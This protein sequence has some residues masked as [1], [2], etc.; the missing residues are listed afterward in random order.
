[1]S[2]T[3]LEPGFQVTVQDLGRIGGLCLGIPT[4]GPMDRESFLLANRLV[5]N[6]DNAAGLECALLGPKLECR[7]DSLVAVTG[8]RVDFKV[9]GKAAPLWAGRTHE[10]H[11]V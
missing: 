1:M 6:A 3:V 8:A 11:L 7:G 9:N 10:G 2:L 4:S 5:G